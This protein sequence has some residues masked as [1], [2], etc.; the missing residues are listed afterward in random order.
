MGCYFDLQEKLLGLP[1]IKLDLLDLGTLRYQISFELLKNNG[2][3]CRAWKSTCLGIRNRLD[4]AV[5]LF[6]YSSCSMFVATTLLWCRRAINVWSAMREWIHELS[7]YNITFVKLESMVIFFVKKNVK[8]TRL[9]IHYELIVSR[10]SLSQIFNTQIEVY[11]NKVIG[12][13]LRTKV[14]HYLYT[15]SNWISN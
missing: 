10:A 1:D 5:S 8:E 13:A 4:W 12:W 15:P 11:D 14:S 9:R 2:F 7:F 6:G 3:I